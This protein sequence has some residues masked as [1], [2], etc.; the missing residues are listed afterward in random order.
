MISLKILPAVALLCRLAN[1]NMNAIIVIKVKHCWKFGT[2]R[3]I[4]FECSQNIQWAN[5]NEFGVLDFQKIQFEFDAFVACIADR[6]P[7]E[8][9]VCDAG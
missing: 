1:V 3:Q 9:L 8:S 5:E 7:K 6:I 2:L 4:S